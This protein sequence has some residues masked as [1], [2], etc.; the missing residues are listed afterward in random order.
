MKRTDL[1]DSLIKLLQAVPYVCI[2][3]VGP[4]GQ[5]W[6]APVW[7]CFD[8]ELNLYWASWPKSQHSLNIAQRP[9]IFVVVYDSGAK[10]EEGSGLYLKMTAKVLTGRAEIAKAR[11]IRNSDFGE[12]LQHEPFIGECPRRLYKAVSQK[13]WQNIDAAIDGNFIDSRREIKWDFGRVAW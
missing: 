5:P 8:D 7:G 10:R 6:N 1:P 4:D 11:Q 2:A 3:S 13:I 12:N 9:D